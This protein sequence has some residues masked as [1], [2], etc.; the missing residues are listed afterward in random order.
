LNIEVEKI[1]NIFEDKIPEYFDHKKSVRS[2]QVQM[3]LDIAEFLHSS[4]RNIMFIEAPVGTGKSLG[5]LAPSFMYGTKYRK[6]INY[7]TSTINLQNQ[8]YESDSVL[9]EQ[10]GLI[11]NTE[12][13]FALGK[14]NYICKTALI[15]RGL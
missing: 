7:A 6:T 1:L 5:V 11:D 12:K 15:Y 14:S 8:I 3:A 2:S 4:S 10:I 13:I 9:L